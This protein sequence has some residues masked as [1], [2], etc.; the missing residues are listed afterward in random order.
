M[1]LYERLEFLCKYTDRTPADVCRAIGAS[2]SLFTDL[3]TGRK[4]SVSLETAVKLADYFQI[5]LDFLAGRM[6]PEI[7]LRLDRLFG[8]K[9][10]EKK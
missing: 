4:S 7:R 2:K 8:K 6:D 10:E 3:K 1:T 5:S 9:T